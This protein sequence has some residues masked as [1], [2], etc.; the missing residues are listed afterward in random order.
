M[1]TK[2]PWRL[3][4]VTLKEVRKFKYRTAVFPFGATEPH[5]LHLPY[6]TDNIECEA[7]CDRACAVAWEKGA[8]VAL[9]PTVPLGAD[10]NLLGFPMTISL[11]QG[12]LDGIVESAAKS[13]ERHGVRKLVVVNGHGGNNFQPGIRT[14]YGKTKV[15]ICLINWYQM[16]SDE[17]AKIFI[18]AD[19]HAGEMETSLVMAL[20]PELVTKSWADDG[21]TYP[22]RLQSAKKGW[23]WYPRPWHALTTNSGV[24]FPH[25]ATGAKGQQFLKTTAARIGQFL[26][27]LDKTP[28]GRHFPYD[29]SKK[30]VPQGRSGG[31]KRKVP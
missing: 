1:P 31:R 20:R 6:A 8:R 11:D 22:S 10:Q 2:Y 17:A 15:F 25:L 26:A 23:V 27:E 21:A 9:L 29:R 14:L 3:A 5:N 28:L 12:Q 18:H 4:E 13:L 30:P 19:D 7:I 16:M 24:G